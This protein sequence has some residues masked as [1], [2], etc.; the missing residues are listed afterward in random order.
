MPP[1]ITLTQA[2]SILVHAAVALISG[3]ALT[4]LTAGYQAAL[5][6]HLDATLPL[7]IFNTFLVALVNAARAYIPAHVPEELAAMK[8]T[9]EAFF[10]WFKQSGLVQTNF[11][12]QALS[13]GQPLVVIHTQQAPVVNQPQQKK[14]EEDT[15]PRT[16]VVRPVHGG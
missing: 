12:G 11:Q 8:D 7:F 2:Q 3:A 6:G 14:L 5:T 16:P 10:T 15:K 13:N 1:K 9:Q 4:A